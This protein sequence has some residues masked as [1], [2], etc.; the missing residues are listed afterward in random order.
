MLT[1]E[2]MNV[3]FSLLLQKILLL[4]FLLSSSLEMCE[5]HYMVKSEDQNNVIKYLIN[6]KI[7]DENFWPLETHIERFPIVVAYLLAVLRIEKKRF[8]LT[9]SRFSYFVHNERGLLKKPFSH[10]PKCK[11]IIYGKAWI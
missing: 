11:I 9:L 3:L 8:L 10:Y 6:N 1:I 2:Q 7:W 4:S 5:E